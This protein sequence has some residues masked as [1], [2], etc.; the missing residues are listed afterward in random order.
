MRRALLPVLLVLACAWAPPVRA[1]EG[2]PSGEGVAFFED[3]AVG[4]ELARET[5]RPLLVVVH[6]RVEAS[7]QAWPYDLVAWRDVYRDPEVVARSRACV[8]VLHRLGVPPKPTG[9]ARDK[10]PAASTAPVGP[11]HMLLDSTGARLLGR[12]EG[13]THAAGAASAK[14]LVGFLDR[15]L[16]R[17]PAIPDE[18]PV[19]D[20]PR[21]AQLRAL[22]RAQVPPPSQPTLPVEASGFRLHLEWPL[23]I[24]ARE[25]GEPLD[26]DVQLYW[27]GEGPFDVGRARIPTGRE[28]AV[29]LDVRFAE[30]PE[31]AARAKEGEHR[32]DVYMEPADGAFAFS[33]GPL[34]VG[35]VWLRF[36]DGGG[37]GGGAGAAEQEPEPQEQEQPQGGQDESE[38]GEAPEPPPEIPENPEVVE[39]FIRDGETVEKDDAIVGV[40]DPDSGVKPPPEAPI[41]PRLRK[42]ERVL[43]TTPGWERIPPS[44]RAFLKRYFEALARAADRQ[45]AERDA[46][47]AP[48]GPGNG[49]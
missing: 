5:G 29:P 44:E 42:F 12:I 15:A 34:H 7:A 35:V 38:E 39:P 23:P 30:H 9:V 18:A 21:V 19:L 40:E 10:R 41:D 48:S 28:V 22:A 13:W 4:R 49:R 31:L 46:G 6:A 3:L 24:P 20:G 1:D 17:A 37:G 32:L 11:T 16:A 43:E 33:E 26:A 45:R 14:A 2:A 27:N 47:A 25:G 36:G 8:C